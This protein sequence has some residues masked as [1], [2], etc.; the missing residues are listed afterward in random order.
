MLR[1]L[2]NLLQQQIRPTVSTRLT[3]DDNATISAVIDE[4]LQR[5]FAFGR[6]ETLGELILRLHRAFQCEAVSVFLVNDTDRTVIV[7]AHAEV[8][9]YA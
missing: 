6:T 8:H 4:L 3:S 1:R 9:V 2:L 7:Y 5:S